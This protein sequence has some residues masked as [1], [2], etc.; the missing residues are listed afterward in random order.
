M[1]GTDV[2]GPARS[3]F[4]ENM[5]ALSSV[6][7]KARGGA[8]RSRTHVRWMMLC[9]ATGLT[10]SAALLVWLIA[11]NPFFAD[12]VAFTLLF[13][14][15]LPLVLFAVLGLI[16][17]TI[18]AA[19]GSSARGAGAGRTR[20]WFIV[21]LILAVTIALG[22]KGVEVMTT[23]SGPPSLKVALIGVDGATW[24]VVD[25]ML[26]SGRLPNL[27]SLVEEG[28]SGVLM[29]V[30]PMFSPRVFT[31]I[32]SGKVADKHGVQGASDTT[33]DAVLVKRVW[34]I[35]WE[36]NEWDYG[37]FEW[38]VTAP[39]FASPNGFNIPGP[40]AI[41]IETVPEELCFVK[42]IEENAGGAQ[43]GPLGMAGLAL[44]SAAHGATV[45]RVVELAE[46]ALLRFQGASRLDTYRREHD[47]IVGLATDAALWQ[48]RRGDIEVLAGVYR[49]TDRLSH[50]YWRY[51]EPEEFSD[52]DPAALDRYRG[53]I[54]DIYAAVDEQFGRLR[55]YLG[56]DGIMMIVS[57][58][59]FRPH[60]TVLAEPFSFRTETLLTEFG[61]D[62]SDL[63]YV[64]LGYGFYLQPLTTDEEKNASRREE[65][66]RLFASAFIAD[67]GDTAFMVSNVDEPGTGD[68]YVK[69]HATRPLLAA[70]PRDPEI[71][72]ANG[73]SIRTTEFLTPTEISGAHDFDGLIVACGPPF[74]PGGDIRD[75]DIFDVTPTLLVAL[76]LPVASDMDG[77]PL[78]S[79]MTPEF[80]AEH[81]HTVIESY[82]TEVRTKKEHSSM[83]EM[84][85]EMK[86]Q[87]RSIGYIE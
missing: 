25:P 54:E 34:D 76:G 21:T 74:I 62:Y 37:L 82:E 45:S 64:N 17:G 49:S 52:T 11:S 57:D 4:G 36:Q 10:A 59:G 43:S 1:N 73:R 42:E 41:G 47:V 27:A 24:K 67:T 28:S 15:A 5:N 40:P 84:S 87:L 50:A 39:P 71:V 31:T 79:A 44:R 70:A 86:E 60:L 6:P 56:P 81:P 12:S 80:L 46:V 18:V 77:T 61:V 78:V 33:T 35:L 69:V 85:E 20:R 14:V 75:A 72:T 23:R 32:A 66:A 2:R 7:A 9:G 16:I 53:T 58:H 8:S 48:L 65:L 83:D 68:D 29:S 30:S 55:R 38:Y 51:Y 26:R 3:P 63:S 19:V 22:G 13:F